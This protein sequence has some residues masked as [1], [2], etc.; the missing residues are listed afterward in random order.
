MTDHRIRL[1]IILDNAAVLRATGAI[2]GAACADA[3]G[4]PFEFGPGGAY[5]ARFPKP[6]VGGVGEMRGSGSFG[7]APGEFTDDTQMAM[8]LAESLVARGGVDPDDLWLRWRAWARTAND[9][10]V[11]TRAALN[12]PEWEGAAA[13]AHRSIGRSASNGALMRS[14]PI[15]LAFA[16]TDP[17]AATEVTM[18]AAVAQ[19]AL[20]HHDPA[21]QWGAALGAEMVRRAI[22]GADPIEQID[23]LLA[24]LPTDIRARFGEMLA[25]QWDPTA[26]PEPRNGSVWGCLAQ[27]V[28]ALRHHDSFHDVVVAAIDLGGD[29][30]TVACVAGALAGATYGVQAIPSRWTTYVHGSVATPEGTQRYDN[31]RLQDLARRLLGLKPPSEAPAETPAGPQ[32]ILDG[33]WA[34][35]LSAAAAH[36]V[37]R[38][39]FAVLSLCRTGKAFARVPTRREVFLIDQAGDANPGLGHV[40]RDAVD[41]IDA[42][43]AEGRQVLVHCHGGRS[44]T[45]LV[46]KAWAMRRQG[47][48]ERQAHD[49][50]GEQW[51]RY[52][53]WNP[54][55]RSFLRDEWAK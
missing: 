42:W 55:F 8:G 29:T 16:R 46:L 37:D 27:A 18:R 6:V 24:L 48:D 2:V 44:R 5:T 45:A 23:E 9:V 41:T 21:A 22:L 39:E 12:Q 13:S 3:L 7:W 32:E 17:S 50:L 15:A 33:V 34:A 26:S 25:P 49:W 36:V 14:A 40:V 10:G 43:R 19:A 31:S 11:N 54:T 1:D 38:P 28:W 30:D 52:D 4:A 51:H 47:W 35:D 20:T 53:P